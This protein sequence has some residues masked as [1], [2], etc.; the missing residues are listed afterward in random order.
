MGNSG[1][2]GYMYSGFI[3]YDTPLYIVYIGWG[4]GSATRR[5]IYVQDLYFMTCY[6]MLFV[7]VGCSNLPGNHGCCHG[8]VS[9]DVCLIVSPRKDIPIA[10][11]GQLWHLSSAVGHVLP[12]SCS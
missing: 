5:A 12:V 7:H 6:H 2:Q 9:I 1:I 3:D 8:T 11:E 4:S 10:D